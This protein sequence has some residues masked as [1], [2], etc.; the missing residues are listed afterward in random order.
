M[1]HEKIRL[2]IAI[3]VSY[4]KLWAGIV[5]RDVCQNRRLERAVSIS[6]YHRKGTSVY[7]GT[8]VTAVVVH[9]R[10]DEVKL[11]VAVEIGGQRSAGDVAARWNLRGR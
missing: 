5:E 11:T 1:G 8:E 9:N 7:V 4:H 10:G 2:A 3:Q 6:E